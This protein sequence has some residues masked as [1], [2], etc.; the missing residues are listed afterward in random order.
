MLQRNNLSRVHCDR[1]PAPKVSQQDL[2]DDELL[3]QFISGL[4]LLKQVS[5]DEPDNFH[6]SNAVSDIVA[7]AASGLLEDACPG[8]GVQITT[9]PN[10]GKMRALKRLA[11]EGKDLKDVASNFLKDI[12]EC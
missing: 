3:S 8:A 4:L 1:H 12:G 5:T 10:P 2:I 7:D 11:K 9:R 6:L